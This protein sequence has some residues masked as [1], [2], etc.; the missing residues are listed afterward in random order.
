MNTSGK[1]HQ[2]SDSDLF[3]AMSITLEIAVCTGDALHL[4]EWLDSHREQLPPAF[5]RQHFVASRYPTQSKA[6]YE[7][8]DQCLGQSQ[9][10]PEFGE[11]LR[12]ADNHDSPLIYALVCASLRENPSSSP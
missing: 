10:P 12:G 4:A 5:R 8:D 7:L 3:I 6:L 11:L 2:I 9:T 1:R